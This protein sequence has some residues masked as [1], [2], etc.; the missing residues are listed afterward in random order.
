MTRRA[1]TR[2]GSAAPPPGVSDSQHAPLTPLVARLPATVPFVAPD[3]IVRSRG[4]PIWLR[5]GA[6]ESAFGPSP[7]AVAAM[8]DA[9]A[10][11]A[12]Y[13]DPESFELRRALG[14][15]HAVPME[16]IAVGAGIDELLGL[17][18]RT[19]VD[20]TRRVVASR[21]SYPT[22][23]YHV[24]GHGG[25]MGWAPYRYDGWN[26]LDALGALARETNAVLVYLAN[27]DNPTG[28]WF[29]WDE[30][31]ELRRALPADCVLVV[32]EAYVEFAPPE[33]QGPFDL[34][35]P[36]VI[37]LRT[38]SKLHGLAGARIGYVL[39]HRATIAA[40]DKVRNH[41][42][43]NCVA[44][45]GAL[46]ALEDR[47]FA[48]G[49]IAEVARGREDYHRLARDLGLSSLP[50]AANFVA[51]DFGSA[52]AARATLGALLERGVFVRMPSVAPID[53]CVRVTV[54]TAKERESF[55]AVLRDVTRDVPETHGDRDAR[56]ER[57]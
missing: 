24:A 11:V 30:V 38:F 29:S 10:H 14:A 42:G 50:S 52:A 6:N 43:T 48:D 8:R 57:G 26:D 3:A 49:V 20:E 44:Q 40:F 22:F 9:L 54:G 13:A 36:K 18:V 53:R 31:A 7:R 56:R 5:V 51:I 1:A 28:T 2:S 35:D 4:Q 15:I 32:D 33:A 45:V 46:A 12:W 25:T 47:T 34:D 17:I 19:F 37:R 39:A 16:C 55:A 21:G 23:A 41:F 27:P